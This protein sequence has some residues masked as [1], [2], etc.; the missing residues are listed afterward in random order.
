MRKDAEKTLAMMHR[1]GNFFISAVSED[2]R[3]RERTIP[4]VHQSLDRLI[5]A[6]RK[7]DVHAAAEYAS[8]VDIAQRYFIKHPD[9]DAQAALTLRV[10]DDLLDFTQSSLG[11]S[12]DQKAVETA[13]ILLASCFA[14]PGQSGSYLET[15]R[16]RLRRRAVVVH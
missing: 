5:P 7:A 4:L 13:G 6:I 8:L 9:E 15:R 16:V 12:A 1:V 11:N 3:W 2:W 14:P 10:S